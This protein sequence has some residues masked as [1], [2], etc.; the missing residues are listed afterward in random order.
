[1]TT[2]STLPARKSLGRGHRAGGLL[3]A[4]ALAMLVTTAY[5]GDSGAERPAL[6]TIDRAAL[7]QL[8]ETRARD[9]LVPGAVVILRTPKGDFTS[10]YG[11]T[12]YR[13]STPTSADQHMRVGSVTKTW[14]GTVILQQVQEGLLKLDDPVSKYVPGVP[15]G[16][17]I[18]I[19]QLLTMRSGLFNYSSM[20]QFNQALDDAPQKVWTQ[21]ELLSLAFANPPYFPPGTGYHYSNTNTILLGLI[22][23][24]RENDKPLGAIMQDRLFTPLGLKGT[25][26]PATTSNLL[27]EPFTHGYM[28]G[29]NVL[30]MAPALPPEM[31]AAARAGTL[32]PVDQTADNPS[33]GWSAGSGYS[34]ANELVT[35]VRALVGGSLLSPE[36]QAKRLAS[37]RPV[38]PNAPDSPQYGLGIAKFGALYGHTGELPGYNTFVGYDPQNNVTLIVWTN[39]EPS[40]D[41]SV[42]ATTLARELIGQVY[43]P[44]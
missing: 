38:D 31:Q 43:A 12:T 35:W 16:D 15:N 6:R 9:M 10:T 20:P 42:P 33:W 1:M 8:V 26:F 22:A 7:Q 28:Y 2:I 30:T 34:T 3:L 13:G 4:A 37:L 29:S 27:P 17:H 14:T 32:A 19:E 44:R 41:G 23:Q 18:T 11:V 25:A 21:Q 36:M 5:G 24:Q 40:P 39:L